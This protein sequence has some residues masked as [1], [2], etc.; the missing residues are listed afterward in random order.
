M[1]RIRIKRIPQSSM[2]VRRNRYWSRKKMVYVLL[3]NRRIRH[4][5]CRHRS[6]ILYIG[7]TEKGAGRP[8]SNVASKAMKAFA[9]IRGVKSV[10]VR[11]LVCEKRKNLPTWELLESALLMVHKNLYGCL[12]YFNKR[13]EG[14]RNISEVGRYFSEHRLRDLLRE[15]DD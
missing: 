8:A 14:F 1:L 5:S 9:E 13:L 3:A 4:H 2:T 6:H 7:T 11:L 10:D 15:L 12:P